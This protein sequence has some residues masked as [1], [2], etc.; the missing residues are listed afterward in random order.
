MSIRVL[1]NGAQGRMGLA[2]VKAI[3]DDADLTLVGALTRHDDLAAAIKEQNADVVLDFTNAEA[4]LNTT[5][6]IINAGARPVVGTS[7]LLP[8]Q[9]RAF[10][11]QCANLKLGGIIAPNF[12]LGAVLVMKHAAEIAHYFPAVEIIEMHHD[13]KLDAPSGTAMRAA[14]LIAERRTSY[15]S[16]PTRH[17]IPGS[18]GA[19]H[20]DIPIHAIRLPGLIAQLQ[21][22]FG[23][24][25]ETVTLRHDSV[26][27][28]SFMPG[29]CLSCKKVM[30]LDTLVYGLENIL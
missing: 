24:T 30:T 19:S 13:G 21:I 15:P 12:S 5:Q 18:R 1:I 16:K 26:D 14:E 9:I 29:V 10:Q 3:S 11:E 27:R 4:V 8:E 25:G 23:G 6:T 22:V 7:G 28:Q 2:S 20:L 17:V